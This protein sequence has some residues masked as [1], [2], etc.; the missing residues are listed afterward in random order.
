MVG[1]PTKTAVIGDVH[2]CGEELRELLA[3]IDRS[4]GSPQLIFVGDLLTKGPTPHVV[5]ETIEERRNSGQSIS[6]VCGNHDQRMLLAMVRVQSGLDPEH[7]G[8]AERQCWHTLH[9]RKCVPDAFRLL[10]EANETVEYRGGGERPW[11]VVHGGIEPKLGLARTPDQVKIHIKAE[12]GEPHWW[13]RYRGE[14][15]LIIVGHKPLLEPMILRR[16]DGTA[17]VAN[18][19][20]GCVYGNILTAY[21]VEADHLMQVPSRQERG[22]QFRALRAADELGSTTRRTS[23]SSGHRDHVAAGRDD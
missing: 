3:D 15:G 1:Y 17:L 22:E 4:V 11:T 5:V 7:L 6:I 2:G 20:T 23:R 10:V 8:R 13:E 9:K 14:D 12:D 19:D 16:R 18:I 21:L